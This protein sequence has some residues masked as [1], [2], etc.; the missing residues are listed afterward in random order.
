MQCTSIRDC[1]VSTA[2]SHRGQEG[3]TNG[4][5]SQIQDEVSGEE[6]SE[7]DQAQNRKEEEVSH[8]FDRLRKTRILSHMSRRCQ[9]TGSANATA[10][11]RRLKSTTEGVGETKG[12]A[13]GVTLL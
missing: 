1:T 3:S 9:K 13:S 12:S 7:E 4:K 6:N 11:R 2:P 5:E 8:N 10:R